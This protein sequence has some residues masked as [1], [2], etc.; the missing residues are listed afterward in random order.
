[1]QKIL[2][3]WQLVLGTV[4]GTETVLKIEK[5]RGPPSF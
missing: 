3:V 2:I 5:K 1:M 4:P